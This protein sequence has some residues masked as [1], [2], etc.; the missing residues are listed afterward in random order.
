MH[1]NW[2]NCNFCQILEASPL[3]SAEYEGL[4]TEVNI[5]KINI[6]IKYKF[7]PVSVVPKTGMN[8]LI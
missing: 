3:I 1:F 5:P 4:K 7:H 6:L 2:N 8:S